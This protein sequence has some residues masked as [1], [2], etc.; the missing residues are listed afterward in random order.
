[1]TEPVNPFLDEDEE[2][3]APE[4]PRVPTFRIQRPTL[5]TS[6]PVAELVAEPPASPVNPL[7]EDDEPEA[8]A[9]VRTLV[10]TPV[11]PVAS[12]PKFGEKGYRK[13]VPNPRRATPRA[14]LTEGGAPLLAFVAKFPGATAEAVSILRKSQASPVYEGG[15][16]LTVPG[17][18]K[19][20]E[21]FKRLGLVESHRRSNNGEAVTHWGATEA[22]VL[23]AQQFGFLEEPNE[24]SPDALEGMSL[25]HLNHL[26]FVALVAAQFASPENFFKDKLSLPPVPLK[27]LIS[28]QQVRRD[29][30][31]LETAL[32]ANKKE[33]KL[34]DFGV[35]RSQKIEE[36]QKE[37]E[38]GF[39]SWNEVLE[40]HPEL[41]VMGLPAS[42]FP[43]SR[44]KTKHLPDLVVSLESVRKGAQSKSI[45]VEIELSKKHWDDYESLLRLY[46]AELRHR[47]AYGR[48][49][50]FTVQNGVGALMKRIDQKHEFGLFKSGALSVIELTHRDGS[51]VK[52]KRRIGD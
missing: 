39:L 6:E 10:T 14:R 18:M 23:A 25:S 28:E 16:L 3:G 33:G 37:V 7:L 26:R 43:N 13:G 2:T 41:R 5:P 29:F 32:G 40:A 44:P 46:A 31:P 9:P 51:P 27:Y 1:M 30:K 15:K 49:I 42:K 12:A 8:P 11:K 24:A 36:I 47:F 20:L 21:K 38:G 34:S 19:Q 52:L 17:A 35:W 50:Y 4:A 22:G 45:M 48:V